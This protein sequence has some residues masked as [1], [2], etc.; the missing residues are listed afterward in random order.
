M[1]LIPDNTELIKARLSSAQESPAIV[2]HLFIFIVIIFNLFFF[3]L[4]S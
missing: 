3:F 2:N 1:N 4:P